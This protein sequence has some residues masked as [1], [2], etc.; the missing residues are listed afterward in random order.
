M[1]ESTFRYK[2]FSDR[3]VK[4]TRRHLTS[5]GTVKPE[6]I[7]YSTDSLQDK[8]SS[9]STEENTNYSPEQE[10]LDPA[11]IPD[12]EA[13]TTGSSVLDA[14]YNTAK[15][16]AEYGMETLPLAERLLG[17]N[18]YGDEGSKHSGWVDSLY[19]MA[20][21]DVKNKNF[22]R[23]SKDQTDQGFQD[24]LSQHLSQNVL[25]PELLAEKL[26]PLAQEAGYTANNREELNALLNRSPGF[27]TWAKGK[28]N[29]LKDEY[30]LEGR[31]YYEDDD[32]IHIKNFNEIDGINVAWSKGDLQL[33][34]AGVYKIQNDGQA[35][36]V[37]NAMF[38]LKDSGT[39]GGGGD[40]FDYLDRT[41]IGT[42]LGNQG[43]GPDNTAAGEIDYNLIGGEGAQMFGELAA[44]PLSM[45]TGNPTGIAKFAKGAMKAPGAAAKTVGKT[46]GMMGAAGGIGSLPYIAG[47]LSN[48]N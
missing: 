30:M 33:P 13:F 23:I 34:N 16:V 44:I 46:A 15:M 31:D 45:M 22:V 41:S 17:V 11:F 21:S 32:S 35:Y 25:T 48:E 47:L 29:E 10:S 1:A 24:Y 42:L 9:I 5:D 27:Q 12:D 2:D 4:D 18:A 14:G 19:G 20:T 38:N 26:M 8:I 7:D 28:T 37:A 6:D 40:N 39:G 43:F 3:N 36:K